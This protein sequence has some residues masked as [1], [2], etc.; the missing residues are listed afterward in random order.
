MYHSS[1]TRPIQCI[2]DN[3]LSRGI[4]ISRKVGV[5][6]PLIDKRLF[7][8]RL[9]LALAKKDWSPTELARQ[10]RPSPTRA[11]A[12]AWANSKKTALPGGGYVL[13]LPGVL[14]VDP[15]W[16]FPR[17]E[18]APSDVTDSRV[19]R[20]PGRRPAELEKLLGMV[21]DALLGAVNRALERDHE[22][23]VTKRG[24]QILGGIFIDLALKLQANGVDTHE[25]L[26]V[27]RE[28][29]KQ[30]GGQ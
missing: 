25:L 17:L 16:L 19:T 12:N 30:G 1:D 22:L 28:L 23:E 7:A 20:L 4:A 13:Q 27:A 8:E 6:K 9:R 24:Y 10:L 5:R 14:G 18:K 29:Q 26:A 3:T 15:D 2:V 11:T 21:R